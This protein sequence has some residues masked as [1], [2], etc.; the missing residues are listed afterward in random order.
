[1]VLQ[2]MPSLKAVLLLCKSSAR[3]KSLWL[4]HH[5]C[6]FEYTHWSISGRQCNEFAQHVAAYHN[7]QP[8]SH[9]GSQCD[10]IR[11]DSMMV[12]IGQDGEVKARL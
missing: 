7:E 8:Y 3:R 4:K 9:A 10:Q 12:A 2:I 1:M 6:P 5:R 11:T